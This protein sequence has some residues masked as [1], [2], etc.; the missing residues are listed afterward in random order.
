M[1]TPEVIDDLKKAGG[2]VE[3][4]RIYNFRCH[5]EATDGTHTVNVEITD[6]GESNPNARYSVLQLKITAKSRGAILEAPSTK[7]WQWFI[8]SI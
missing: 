7:R 8:G 6:M 2:F 4:H 3:V 5:R 1:N